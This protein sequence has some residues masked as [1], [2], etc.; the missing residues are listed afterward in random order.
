M[1]ELLKNFDYYPNDLSSLN[2]GDLLVWNNINKETSGVFYSPVSIT[3]YGYVNWEK[4][5]Y[6]N[7]VCVWEG[8]G[9]I[10]DMVKTDGN[11]DLPF[12]IRRRR[13]EDLSMPGYM[14]R[15]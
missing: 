5:N 14:I 2:T 8:N 12:I 9:F 7:H 6:K 10:T 3:Q 15:L 11:F 1:P 13:L 4:I